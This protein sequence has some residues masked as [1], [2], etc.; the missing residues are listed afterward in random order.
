MF[1]FFQS[2][3][4]PYSTKKISEGKFLD[5]AEEVDVHI[6][7]KRWMQKKPRKALVGCWFVIHEDDQYVYWG[8]PIFKGIFSDDRRVDSFY[9]TNKEALNQAFPNYKKIYGNTIRLKLQEVIQKA[10][11]EKVYASVS[12]GFKSKLLDTTIAIETHSTIKPHSTKEIPEPESKKVSYK[13]VFEKNTL[14]LILIEEIK[15]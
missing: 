15:Q 8:W 13:V 11:T 12:L 7:F 3:K 6:F 14:D 5:K 2:N 10:H 9:K 1:S 4:P